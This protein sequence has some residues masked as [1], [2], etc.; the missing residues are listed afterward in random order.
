MSAWIA[1]IEVAFIM[2]IY[3]VKNFSADVDFMLNIKTS[4]ILKALW[5]MIPT[6]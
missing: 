2:W 4:I 6:C 5:V 1:I 3:G